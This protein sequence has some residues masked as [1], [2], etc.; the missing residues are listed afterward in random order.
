MWRQNGPKANSGALFLAA[1]TEKDVSQHHDI[2]DNGYNKG[3]DL[4]VEAASKDG[5]KTKH[6]G[7]DYE[8]TVKTVD[9]LLEP[10]DKGINHGIAVDG[11]VAVL[12]VKITD[13][14]PL[15]DIR[16]ILPFKAR[17]AEA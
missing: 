17:K 6:D 2:E 9:G 5:G 7:I 4:I 3:R 15:A 12:T 16:K 11:K 13:K 8:T 10:G 14:S 1:S